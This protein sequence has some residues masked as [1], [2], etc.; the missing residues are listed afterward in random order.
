MIR[1]SPF[2]NLDR[3]IWFLSL[4]RFIRAMGRVS[5]FLFLPLVFVEVYG[6]SFIETGLFLGFAVLIMA[7]VQ[8]FSGKW[9]DRIGRRFFFVIVPIPVIVFYFFIFAAISLRLSVLFLISSW[10]IVIIF[11]SIQYPAIQASVA[12]LT[13]SKDRLTGF[14][15]LRLMANLGAAVGPI[16]GGFLSAYGF[17]YIFLLAGSATVLEVFILYRNVSETYIIP[18]G[19]PIKKEKSRSAL[20]EA[21]KSRVFL[22]FTLIGVAMGFVLRQRGSTLVLYIFDLRNLPVMEVG[23]IYALNGLL[24][25][26]L[27]MPILSVMNRSRTSVFWRGIGGFFYA[28]GFLILA[29]FGGLTTFLIVMAIMTVGEN[30]FSPT[31][32]TIITNI[33][34][35]NYRGTYIG[36]YNLFS[37]FGQ[38]LGS[39]I[40]LWLLYISRSV[41]GQFW[42]YITLLAI[43]CSVSY[44]FLSPSYGRSSEDVNGIRMSS[45]KIGD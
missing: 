13:S 5:S 42:I 12:D 44:L 7:F 37:S 8:F 3:R 15:S 25:V 4:S 1:N 32:Q 24:V 28:G 22:T 30:F 19:D 41:T 21:M 35:Y 14:T 16:I 18:K 43:V 6:A 17:Q 31:T 20:K 39:V 38:F 36:I 45:S 9:T 40:G 33:A 10:Y 26:L 2:R 34:G 27:Q 29:F 23:Y 11:N